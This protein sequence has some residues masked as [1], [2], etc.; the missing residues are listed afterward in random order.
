MSSIP[1]FA[2]PIVMRHRLPTQCCEVA[3]RVARAP[4][5]GLG[6]LRLQVVDNYTCI[7][8]TPGKWSK[9]KK[10][11]SKKKDGMHLTVYKMGPF[12]VSAT[13]CHVPCT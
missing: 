11:G 1:V 12:L 7:M 2:R 6:P 10:D 9:T 8:D 5:V 3:G 4:R 13:P